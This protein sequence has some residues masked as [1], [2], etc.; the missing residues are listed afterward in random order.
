M[1]PP[2]SGARQQSS[3][4]TRVVL[5]GLACLLAS[6]VTPKGEV[7]AGC[8]LEREV[9]I[10]GLGFF[11]VA[12]E[13]ECSEWVARV[14]PAHAHSWDRTGGWYVAGGGIADYRT[15]HRTHGRHDQWRDYLESLPADE[16]RATIDRV[17]GSEERDAA[18]ALAFQAWLGSRPE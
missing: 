8:H 2:P 10:G 3:P 13:N 14:H 6:C 16:A 9:A 7:C 18:T 12:S 15:G 4:R 5:I 17:C 1:T 11:R